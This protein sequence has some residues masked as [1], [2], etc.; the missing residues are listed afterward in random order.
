MTEKILE[1]ILLGRD[2]TRQIGYE[3]DDP[4]IE[5]VFEFDIQSKSLR[6]KL[7][8]CALK[9]KNTKASDQ[10][11]TNILGTAMTKGELRAQRNI[12]F[13]DMTLDQQPLTKQKALRGKR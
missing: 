13:V 6:K 8:D 4:M 12:K 11:P 10:K 7:K 5:Y 2:I 3:N 1:E 9:R